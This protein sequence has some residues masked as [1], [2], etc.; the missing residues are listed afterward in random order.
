MLKKQA[1]SNFDS[2]ASWDTAGRNEVGTIIILWSEMRL[3]WDP[4]LEPNKTLDTL[5]TLGTQDTQ[6]TAQ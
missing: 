3:F 4:I 2:Q 5:E 6:R 1:T